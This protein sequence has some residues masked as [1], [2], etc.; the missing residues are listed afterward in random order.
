[1]ILD[2]TGTTPLVFVVEIQT[3]QLR[4]TASNTQE[5]SSPSN[6]LHNSIH[7]NLPF[8]GTFIFQWLFLLSRDDDDKEEEREIDRL[9]HPAAV[10]VS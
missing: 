5:P 9:T 2:P 7:S 10:A 8:A 6:K 4:V 1:M 3:I